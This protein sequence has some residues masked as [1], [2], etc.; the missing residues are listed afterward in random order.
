[1]LKKSNDGDTTNIKMSVTD[2]E[3]ELHRTKKFFNSIFGIN[4]NV[5]KIENSIKEKDIV[6]WI[7]FNKVTPYYLVL[8]PLIKKYFTNKVN[9][10]FL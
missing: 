4:Y 5:S 1:M 7:A 8:S 2:L 6:K 9:G 10:W 3:I